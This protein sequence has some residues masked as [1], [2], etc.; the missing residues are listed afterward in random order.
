MLGKQ[1][2]KT[3]GKIWGFFYVPGTTRDSGIFTTDDKGYIFSEFFKIL[4]D[5]KGAKPPQLMLKHPD[6]AMDEYIRNYDLVAVLRDPEGNKICYSVNYLNKLPAAFTARLRTYLQLMPDDPV[7]WSD[8]VLRDPQEADARQVI[9]GQRPEK[10]P[11]KPTR[12]EVRRHWAHPSELSKPE[13][14]YLTGKTEEPPQ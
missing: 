8:S 13:M 1:K 7:L 10:P 4:A 6:E 12:A 5:E 2:S 9:Y 11:R 3:R 14:D